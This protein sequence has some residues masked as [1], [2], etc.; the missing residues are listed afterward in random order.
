MMNRFYIH[1]QQ[2]I[3]HTTDLYK[4]IGDEYLHNHDALLMNMLFKQYTTLLATNIF[5][6]TPSHS[7]PITTNFTI[8]CSQVY[9]N[10]YVHKT[11][12]LPLNPSM[13][14]Y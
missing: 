2:H 5:I 1:H 12:V 7:L 13:D 8:V 10:I 9:R 4:C 14:L 3:D 6:N 11:F